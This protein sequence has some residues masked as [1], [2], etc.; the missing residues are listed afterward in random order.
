MKCVVVHLTLM[1]C[2]FFFFFFFFFYYDVFFFFFLFL[3]LKLLFTVK[4]FYHYITLI[5]LYIVT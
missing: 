1:L 4:L 3:N 2:F 5:T